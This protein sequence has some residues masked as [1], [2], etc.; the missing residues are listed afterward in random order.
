MNKWDCETN[1]CFSE[2]QEPN[3]DA[4]RSLSLQVDHYIVFAFL[5]FAT[6]HGQIL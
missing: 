4:D 6:N 2:G 5:V 1:Y 3:M